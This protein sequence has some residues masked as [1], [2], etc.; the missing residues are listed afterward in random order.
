VADIEPGDLIEAAWWPESVS[1][2][3][4]TDQL[5]IT[6]TSSIAGTPECSTTFVAPMSG[7]V[8]ICVA[9]EM[10]N[11]DTAGNRVFVQPQVY[12]GTSSAGTLVL[13]VAV[14]RGVSTTGDTTASQF[15]T[16]GNMT[17]L[18]GLTGGSTYFVRTMHRVDGGTTNDI[19]HRRL[20]VIPLT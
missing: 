15:M 12:L 10:R 18:E 5:N 9:A 17:M 11:D 6:S 3:E 19:G 1:V 16:H 13:A 7:R 2:Q 20:I 4:N 14:T 8:G